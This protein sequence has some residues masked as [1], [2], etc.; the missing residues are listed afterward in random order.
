MDKHELSNAANAQKDPELLADEE[1]D[2]ASGGGCCEDKRPKRWTE[3]EVYCPRGLRPQ[4]Y[5]YHNLNTPL[6]DKCYEGT[7]CKWATGN[8]WTRDRCTWDVW[9]ALDTLN[10][11]PHPGY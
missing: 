3:S 5:G 4:D 7:L 10:G 6:V 8:N 1:L 9:D 11:K 2:A